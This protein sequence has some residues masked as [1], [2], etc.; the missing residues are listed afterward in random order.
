MV[1]DSD[2]YSSQMDQEAM[3]ISFTTLLTSVCTL[4]LG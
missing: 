1:I 2:E 4:S 3:S